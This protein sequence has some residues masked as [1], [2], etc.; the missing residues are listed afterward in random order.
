MTNP[1]LSTAQQ[2]TAL[3]N[4]VAQLQDGLNALNSI[5]ANQD[6]NSTLVFT[7]PTAA[8]AATAAPVNISF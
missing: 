7:N 3:N 1:N 5:A 4:G 8:P 6:A 2:T